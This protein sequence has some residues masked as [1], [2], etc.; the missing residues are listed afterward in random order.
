M[1]A[2]PIDFHSEWSRAI[3]IRGARISEIRYPPL[4][5]CPI[6][7]HAQPTLGIVLDGEIRK[8]FTNS[9][10]HVGRHCGFT[11]PA[12]MLHSD[13]F[14]LGGRVVTIELDTAH[15]VTAERM[16]ICKAVF[17][18]RRLLH[19][20]RLAGLAQ[21]VV[22]E[23]RRPDG[24]TSLAMDALVGEIL[25]VATRV[26]GPEPLPELPGWLQHVRDIAQA[27]TGRR[28]TVAEMAAEVGMHP[29]YLARRFRAEFGISPGAFARNAR[30][31]WAADQLIHSQRTIAEIA[32]EAGFADQSHFTRAFRRYLDCTPAQ[33]R[34]AYLSDG[35]RMT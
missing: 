13:D 15:P 30:L 1:Q 24:V 21:R 23:L 16:S 3:T 22:A 4:K 32:I 31:Q 29:A 34:A 2:L 5:R 12:G 6:H 20:E 7:F 17:D 27:R 10:M 35:K 14:S 11:M 9:S 19:D 33:Y 18:Q 25:A 28:L 26:Q 8:R